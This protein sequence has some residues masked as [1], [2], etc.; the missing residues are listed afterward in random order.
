MDLIQVLGEPR[1]SV[2]DVFLRM[3]QGRVQVDQGTG[4]HYRAEELQTGFLTMY[5]VPC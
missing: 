4:Q 3:M 2:D 5:D 1:D